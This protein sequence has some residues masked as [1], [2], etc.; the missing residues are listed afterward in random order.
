M[1]LLFGYWALHVV[2]ELL[3]HKKRLISK[4]ERLNQILN[5]V[6]LGILV[7]IPFGIR[8][9]DHLHSYFGLMAL[10]SM[11]LIA[12]QEWVP[13]AFSP[14]E[15]G[16][17]SLIYMLHPIVIAFLGMLWMLLSGIS[18]VTEMVLPFSL[19]GLRSL[20]SM[21]LGAVAVTAYYYF[22]QYRKLS[23]PPL[24]TPGPTPTEAGPTTPV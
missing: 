1:T 17:H 19:T 24:P 8:Y 10:S 18:L 12:R 3:F 7:F 21:Y 13:N 23:V 15:R 14:K 20:L 16:L 2:D 11:V 22:D 6:F 9:S 5:M 4:T